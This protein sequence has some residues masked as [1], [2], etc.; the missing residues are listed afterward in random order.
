MT[1]L[2]SR[3]CVNDASF[4]PAVEPFAGANSPKAGGM[5]MKRPQFGA[6]SLQVG[7]SIDGMC[8]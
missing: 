4:K 5:V 7:D 3:D 6:R 8:T 1:S 2:F